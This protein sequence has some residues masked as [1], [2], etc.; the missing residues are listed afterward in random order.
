MKV[1]DYTISVNDISERLC[2]VVVKVIDFGVK[3][4]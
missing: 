3:Q 4:T 2:S 1:S